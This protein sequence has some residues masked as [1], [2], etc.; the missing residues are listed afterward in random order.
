MERYSLIRHLAITSA[1]DDED[2]DVIARSSS[3]RLCNGD[4]LLSILSRCGRLESLS[5][6]IGGALLR[7]ALL[8]VF[9]RLGELKSF[10]LENSANESSEPMFVFLNFDFVGQILT[11]D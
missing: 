3:S 6:N 4:P 9:E 1:S 8:P 11:F 10:T 7:T 2:T 5:L